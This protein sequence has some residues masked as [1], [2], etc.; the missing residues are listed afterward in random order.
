MAHL[1]NWNECPFRLP[2]RF[3]GHFSFKLWVA[4]QEEFCCIAQACVQYVM[5]LRLF[6]QVC[7]MSPVFYVAVDIPYTDHSFRREFSPPRTV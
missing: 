5:Y 2:L 6:L 4:S 7:I 1:T 3:Y